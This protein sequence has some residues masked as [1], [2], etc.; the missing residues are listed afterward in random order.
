MQL[1]FCHVQMWEGNDEARMTK[2]CRRLNNKTQPTTY[3][4]FITH[5]IPL[6]THHPLTWH[7]T[8][9][10]RASSFVIRHSSFVIRHWCL[11]I[12]PSSINTSEMPVRLRSEQY[13]VLHFAPC[14]IFA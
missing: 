11:V 9:D 4:L 8:F 2:E 10:I 5:L 7:S 6:I 3:W 14:S 13:S 1:I 12:A